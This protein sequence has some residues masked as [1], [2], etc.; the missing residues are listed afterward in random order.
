[1]L[2]G[3]NSPVAIQPQPNYYIRFVKDLDSIRA[4]TSSVAMTHIML[5]VETNI[6]GW[7]WAVTS[8]DTIITQEGVNWGDILWNSRVYWQDAY[9]QRV[10]AV[11][12]HSQVYENK[13][14]SAYGTRIEYQG[15]T[16]TII[17]YAY[18]SDIY[19]ADTMRVV[20]Y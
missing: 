4:P 12:S 17:A 10:P 8:R 20:I 16:D 19:I 13:A 2:F 1:M 3:C 5:E 18:M 7:N 6:P 14:F 9:G 11:N 15:R